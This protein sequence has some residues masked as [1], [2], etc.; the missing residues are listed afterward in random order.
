M[1]E[2]WLCPEGPGP[3]GHIERLCPEGSLRLAVGSHAAP[4]IPDP[5]CLG[6]GSAP[7]GQFIRA[8]PSPPALGN[9]GSVSNRRLWDR[10][11]PALL[12]QG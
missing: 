3:H 8:P 6:L 4:G 1:A 2:A 11:P 9:T 5:P 10:I 12:F 7:R